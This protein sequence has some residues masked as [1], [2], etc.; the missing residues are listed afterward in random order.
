MYDENGKLSP[1]P[2]YELRLLAPAGADQAERKV[3]KS[4]SIVPQADEGNACCPPP[5]LQSAV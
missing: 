1:A 5:A 2:A 3:L 4:I